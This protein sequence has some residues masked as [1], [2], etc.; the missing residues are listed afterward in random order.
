MIDWQNGVT[1]QIF[2]SMTHSNRMEKPTVSVIVPVYNVEAYLSRCIESIL[3]QTYSNLELLL[4]DD[5]SKDSSGSI[6]DDLAIKDNRIRVI[7]KINGGVSSARNEGLGRAIGQYIMFVD[8]DD[9]LSPD[10]VEFCVSNAE[11]Y[12]V[13]RFSM[14]LENG[15]CCSSRQYYHLDDMISKETYLRQIIAR[16]TIL[17]VCGGLYR[18]DLFEKY[19]IRFDTDLICGEDWLVLFNIIKHCKSVLTT[20]KVFYH[21]DVSREGSCTNTFSVA[22]SLT[23]IKA[24]VRIYQDAEIIGKYFKD[25][26]NGECELYRCQIGSALYHTNKV[27]NLKTLLQG[28]NTLRYYP[29]MKSIMNAKIPCSRKWMLLFFGGLRRF[30]R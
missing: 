12:E 13:V 25:K 5:G 15:D 10:A 30:V 29:S 17:G 23:A 22:K 9:W 11:C 19:G 8:A 3:S 21:Y 2:F 28:Y 7:H 16:K 27:S 14:E 26:A 1:N 24:L 6:C 20:S 18:R 4:V